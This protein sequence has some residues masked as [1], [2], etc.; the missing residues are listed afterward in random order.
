MKHQKKIIAAASI[1]FTLLL[2]AAQANVVENGRS[3]DLTANNTQGEALSFC[4][5]YPL[6][7]VGTDNNGGGKE[8]GTKYESLR[9]S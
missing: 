2:T 6:L 4:Q 1:A 7:C 8:P 3:K 5:R 9:T